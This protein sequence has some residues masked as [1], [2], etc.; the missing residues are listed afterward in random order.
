MEV[1]EPVE[2]EHAVD[3]GPGRGLLPCAGERFGRQEVAA[4][5]GDI[6]FDDKLLVVA[7]VAG[8]GFGGLGDVESAVVAEIKI[9]PAELC[10]FSIQLE[11]KDGRVCID[12]SQKSDKQESE[13]LSQDLH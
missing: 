1:V 2:L 3:D 8:D 4:V 5:A 9:V 13:K 11:G 7:N 6:S 10:S 12:N